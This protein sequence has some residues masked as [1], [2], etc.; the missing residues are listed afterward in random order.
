MKEEYEQKSIILKGKHGRDFLAD[1]TFPNK[2]TQSPVIIFSHGFKGFKDWGPFNEVASFFAEK[3]F[4]FL[5]FNYSFN[6]TTLENPID[7]V[8]LE[9]F[10]NNNFTKELDDLDVVIA[11]V[12]ENANSLRADL[13]KLLLVGH[14]RGGGVSILKG[15][16][17]ERIRSVATWASVAEFSRHISKPE[18]LYW[19]TNGVL[20]IEN[21]RTGQ[22][23]PLFIQLYNDYMKNHKRFNIKNA[24]SHFNKPLLIAHGT[25]DETVPFSHALELVNLNTTNA[26]LLEIV[27]ADH[28]FGAAHPY[29]ILGLPKHFYELVIETDLFFKT[30]LINH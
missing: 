14:S 27:S 17:D 20:Y 2:E 25:L 21:G 18:I 30:T 3:G 16:E 4:I 9:A 15:F 29:D 26:K 13:S 7:F 1:I 28:T 19:K 10:G 6:G 8:D 23:M 11:W 24:V 5:K 22:Q 12:T